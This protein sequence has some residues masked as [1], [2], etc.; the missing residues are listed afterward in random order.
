MI[1]N[2]KPSIYIAELIN[3]LGDEKKVNEIMES[4]L[5][6]AQACECMK[7]DDFDNFIK[8][9]EKSITNYINSILP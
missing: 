9:R 6:S 2:K 8:E 7:S 1:L 5:I 4:H 3:K